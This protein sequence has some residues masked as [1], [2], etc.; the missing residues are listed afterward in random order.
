M[1]KLI[2]MTGWVM[3]EHGVE[4]SHLTVINKDEELTKKRH[5]AFWRCKCSCGEIKSYPG[6]KIRSGLIKH[7]GKCNNHNF[8]NMT[9]WKMW[10]HGIQDSKLTVIKRVENNYYNK[11]YS[12]MWL[13]ECNCKNHSQIITTSYSLR[14]GLTKS[15]GCL[16]SNGENYIVKILEQN[17]LKYLREYTFPDLLSEKNAKLRFDFAIFNEKNELLFLLEY[18]GK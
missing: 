15:C 14:A 7:C 4:D 11:N 2:D 12:T 10:E 18:D 3:K 1:G 8:I 16:R 13:C 5:E 17:N 6:Y 9:G